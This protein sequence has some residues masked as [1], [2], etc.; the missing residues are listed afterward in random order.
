MSP[1]M[2]FVLEVDGRRYTPETPPDSPWGVGAKLVR[3][4]SRE[5]SFGDY[6]LIYPANWKRR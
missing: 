5:M 3:L 1:A 2:T 6:Q 4:A